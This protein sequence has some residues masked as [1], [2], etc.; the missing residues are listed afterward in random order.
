M[1]GKFV[2]RG[3]GVIST[4]II[5]RMLDPTDFGLVAI[6]M[7]VIGFGNVLTQIGVYRYLILKPEICDNDL[8]AAWTINII[9]RSMVVLGLMI[10]AP[11]IAQLWGDQN[12]TSVIRLLAI[13]Q[14]ISMFENVGMIYFEKNVSFKQTAKL[15][16]VAKIGSFIVTVGA[17]VVLKNYMALVLGAI[18]NA[19]FRT[20]FSYYISDYRP[21]FSLK[22]D[23]DM[24]SVSSHIFLRNIIGYTRSQMDILLIG[25]FFG[26]AAAGKFNIAKTFAIMPQTEL[27]SPAMKPFFS[28][29]SKQS[30]DYGLVEKKFFQ[31]LFIS[32]SLAFPCIVGLNALAEPFTLVVLGEKWLD[33]IPFIGILG[34][35]MLPFITQPLLFNLYDFKGRSK[36]GVL[37]DIFGLVAILSVFALIKPAGLMEFTELRI[38]VA[39]LSFLFMT[40]LASMLINLS[41]LSLLYVIVVILIPTSIMAVSMF[42]VMPLLDNLSPLMLLA[43]TAGIGGSI[44][45]IVF[46]LLA[47]VFKRFERNFIYSLYPAIVYKYTI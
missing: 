7:L 42:F 4:L 38:F 3:L 9:L 5:V 34:F 40:L 8:N 6:A 12:I 21:G 35:I 20:V 14:I 1:T 26:S 31:M 2:V 41:W 28:A 29:S 24:F 25:Q 18:T 16:M 19:L 10:L 39:L 13:V 37:N 33:V 22:I 47:S 11:Y 36:Y 45:A 30:S 17:A 44:Y 46:W 32:L 27:I 23:S 15:G 43:L